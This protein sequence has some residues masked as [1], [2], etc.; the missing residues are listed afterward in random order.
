[1]GR[2]IKI[3]PKM[4][5]KFEKK[6]AKK[7]RGNRVRKALKKSRRQILA[8]LAV[9]SAGVMDLGGYQ[10]GWYGAIRGTSLVIG[11]KAPYWLFVEKGRGPGGMPPLSKI[12]PWVLRHGM[13]AN[14][15]FP[16]ARKIAKRGITGRPY[17]LLES[18]QQKI[19]DIVDKNINSW[20]DKA[21]SD[22]MR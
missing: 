2:R 21:F 15:A 12:G 8:M 18:T 4:L 19:K 17:F 10:K 11:N 6:L 9:G 7:F 14:A 5:G 16:V 13:K 1:M 20:F 22:S 3:A